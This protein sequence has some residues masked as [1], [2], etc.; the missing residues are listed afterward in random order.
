LTRVD[1]PALRSPVTSTRDKMGH[2]STSAAQLP[3]LIPSL[4]LST[5]SQLLSR[6]LSSSVGHLASLRTRVLDSSSR[7][8]VTGGVQFLATSVRAGVD[9]LAEDGR[10]RLL[11]PRHDLA[12]KERV[13]EGTTVRMRRRSMS[14]RWS[15]CTTSRR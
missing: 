1:L 7:V 5:L 10:A 2:P 15:R 4:S 6:R 3:A 8:L 9:D 13:D 12:A 11:V 14:T